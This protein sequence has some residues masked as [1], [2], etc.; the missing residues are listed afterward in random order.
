MV[1]LA[2]T[3]MSHYIRAFDGQT[4]WKAWCNTSN[5]VLT[6]K[7]SDSD[8]CISQTVLDDVPEVLQF[9]NEGRSVGFIASIVPDSSQFCS[10]SDTNV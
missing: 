2:I 9:L 8:P 10:L 4:S 5:P 7:I 3:G 1:G 6:K